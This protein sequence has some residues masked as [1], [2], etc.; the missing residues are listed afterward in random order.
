MRSFLNV[1]GLNNDEVFNLI[2][3]AIYYKQNDTFYYNYKSKI[4]ANMF[5]ENSTRTK[6]S[7]EIAER[8]LGFRV[9]NFS[10]QTSSM[11]K[12]ESLYDT[13]KTFES[14]GV[15]A[16]VIRHSLDEYY[17]ELGNINVKLINAGD[18]AGSHP[19]QCLLDLVTIYEQFGGFEGLKV[20]IVGDIKNSRVAKS[21]KEALERLGAKVLLV[22][23]PIYQD[24]Q[25]SEYYKL[26]DILDDIDVCMLLRIQHERHTKNELDFNKY[27]ANFALKVN[28]YG[29]LKQNAII[30][31]PAPVNRGVEIDSELVESE[32]SKIFTQMKNGVF[33]R[34]AI[35][36]YVFE[37]V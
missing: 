29:R 25:F 15:D 28:D 31:H 30:M 13:C 14:L 5:F 4:I 27:R 32:K 34:M 12:G 2:N 8:K 26:N 35:L 16:L 37:R 33:A 36:D 1:K 22:A 6:M 7:F 19:S 11:S 23:P 17:K 21:N 24:S 3:R 18:G 9:L 10:A 20:A